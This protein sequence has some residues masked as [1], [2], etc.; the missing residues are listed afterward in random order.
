[1]MHTHTCFT[2]LRPLLLLYIFIISTGV[3]FAQVPFHR[4]PVVRHSAQDSFKDTLIKKKF[5]RAVGE[6]LIAELTP[7]IFDRYVAQKD[8]ARISWKTV[9]HNL[10]PGSW[11]WD[12]DPFQ[13]NQFGHPY[14][15]SL[16]YSAFRSNGYTFWQS[17]PAAVVGSYL[18]ETFAENQAPA[19]NDLINTSFGGIVLGEMT[20]RFS[21]KIVNNR[22][23]GF[24]RQAREVLGFIVNPMNGLNRLLDGKWG[25]VYGSPKDRDSTRISAELDLGLRNVNESGKGLRAGGHFGWYGRA[26]ML[27]GDPSEDLKTPFSNIAVTAE[28]GQ[29]DSTNVN[30]ISV[31]G[32]L[33]GWDI[34]IKDNIRNLLIL[35]ANYDYI[36]NR[37]FFYGGQSVKF[38]ML[39]E[40]RFNKNLKINTSFGAGPILLAAIPDPYLFKGRN[41][42]YGPGF[43][44]NGG[45]T[46]S[47]FNKIFYGI[48][49]RGGWMI[50]V[51]GNNSH[52]FLHAVSSELSY[53]FIKGFSICAEPGYFRLEGNY[54][55]HPDVDKTYPYLRVSTRYSVIF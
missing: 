6:L 34:S 11:T 46:I 21:N 27:Y 45:G 16:F 48:N 42:D 3:L 50:T 41:Y 53:M 31:Y 8:Y 55:D 38:N 7:W 1:M 24:K 32:S 9:G 5:G 2:H 29:D 14:H 51:N 18:W 47:I 15:G 13:T 10:N 52:Y 39:S 25:K 49:Y 36:H 33:A 28:F 23:R 40:Y 20:Y 37:A 22:Q 54:K 35:S 44:I 12:N 43:A 17:A 30:V 4:L 26:R 19:P